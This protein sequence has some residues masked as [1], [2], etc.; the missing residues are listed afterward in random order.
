MV[1]I[2]AL[3]S[4]LA[5][6]DNSLTFKGWQISGYVSFLVQVVTLAASRLA[7]LTINPDK[8]ASADSA[9]SFMASAAK[10]VAAVK[11]VEMWR[12]L[13]CWDVGIDGESQLIWSNLSHYLHLFTR[14]SYMS[15]Q[16]VVWD[17]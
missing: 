6:Q 5:E 17:F 4:I 1:G 7:P 16:V 12:M 3:P 10:L 11:D 14:V 13:R 2:C 9:D 8:A 15:G